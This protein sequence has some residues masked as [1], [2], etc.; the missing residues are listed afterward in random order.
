MTGKGPKQIPT[1]ETLH[2]VHVLEQLVRGYMCGSKTNRWKNHVFANSKTKSIDNVQTYFYRFEFQQR[3]TVYLHM[4]VWLKD[5]K[6]LKP[7]IT[8]RADIP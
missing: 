2:I 5:L 3:G 4:L 1:L 6:S 8:I 7:N